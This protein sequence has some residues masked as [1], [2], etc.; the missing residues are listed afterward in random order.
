[1]KTDSIYSQ[2]RDKMVSE[3]YPRLLSLMLENEIKSCKMIIKDATITVFSGGFI[4]NNSNRESPFLSI[5]KE[6]CEVF[7]Y[8]QQYIRANGLYS[9]YCTGILNLLDDM[10]G[11][12]Q[13]AINVLERIEKIPSVCTREVLTEKIITE[14]V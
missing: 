5:N 6:K 13:K 2:L 10:Q 1:M 9:E 4:H 3:V 14:N 11:Y 12:K 7:S 8:E